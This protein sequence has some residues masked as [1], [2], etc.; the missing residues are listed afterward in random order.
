MHVVVDAS[1]L[2]G[3]L[4]DVHGKIG[5]R[6]GQRLI[7]LVDTDQAYVMRTLTKLEA[8]AALRNLW[9][10]EVRSSLV[11]RR[12]PAPT[13]CRTTRARFWHGQGFDLRWRCD[14][15]GNRAGQP[16]RRCT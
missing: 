1:L 6:Y 3:M 14:R 9:V 12:F 8:T 13:P 11:R 5:H 15:R 4:V 2:A 7:D 10:V 16:V